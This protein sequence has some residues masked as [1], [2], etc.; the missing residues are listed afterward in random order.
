VKTI[1]KV[2]AVLIVVGGAALLSGELIGVVGD[3]P[4]V[5]G[6]VTATIPGLVLALGGIGVL[7]WHLLDDFF[8]D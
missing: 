4:T 3:G 7:T 1:D 2:G 8:G 6:L 5:T